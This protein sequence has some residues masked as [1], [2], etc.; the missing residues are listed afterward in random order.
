MARLIFDQGGNLYGTTY[1]GG[2]A[3]YCTGNGCGVVFELTPGNNSQWTE[4]VI[5][6]FGTQA[7]DGADPVNGLIFDRTGNLYGVTIWGGSGEFSSCFYGCGT[8]F[9]MTPTG[10]GQWTE[11]VLHNFANNG[12]DGIYP[13]SDLVFDASGNL[14][15]TTSDGGSSGTGCGP[16]D[17]YGTV[18]ELT[19]G[20]NGQWTETVLHNFMDNGVDG[21]NPDPTSGLIFDG[22]GNLYGTTQYGG[23]NNPSCSAWGCGTVFELTP[24]S[25][26]WTEPY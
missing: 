10:N 1:A 20:S 23:N 6:T 17:G 24:G 22:A 7:E 19:P 26:S 15:G 2:L 14:C 13:V 8:V 9:E 12:T 11:T 16:G 25:G 3:G 18:F 4:K 5:H 21:N